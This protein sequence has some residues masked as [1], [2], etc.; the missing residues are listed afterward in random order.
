MEKNACTGVIL[1]GGLNVRFN[2]KNK[3]FIEI[4]GRKILDR[5]L[6]VFRELFAETII[7]TNHP[8]LYMDYD[9]PI[10]TDIYSVRSP[11]TGIHAGL[12]YSD[13]PFSFICACDTPFLKPELVHLI[14]QQIEPGYDVMIPQTADGLEALCAAYS[15]QCLPV[16][17]QQLSGHQPDADPASRQLKRGLQIK[18]FYNKVRVKKLPENLLREIDPRLVS[19][20]NV[21]KPEDLEKAKKMLV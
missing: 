16:I 19:F 1:A 6:S 14:I 20:F 11:L 13:S 10:V 5:I 3:A 7:V 2:G 21:N 8:T 15:R 9:T 4:D 17:N 12:T 18:Q